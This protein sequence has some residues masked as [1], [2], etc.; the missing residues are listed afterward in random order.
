MTVRGI[1][2]ITIGRRMFPCRLVRLIVWR[3]EWLCRGSI[4]RQRLGAGEFQGLAGAGQDNR[5]GL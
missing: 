1:R 3:A 4:P 2:G 5:K